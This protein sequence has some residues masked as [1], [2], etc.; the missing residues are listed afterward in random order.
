MNCGNISG[1][2][3][4]WIDSEKI[5]EIGPKELDDELDAKG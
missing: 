2:G 4:E 5:R 1:N 3:E